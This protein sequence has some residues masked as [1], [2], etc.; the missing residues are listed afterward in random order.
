M[1]L[2]FLLL[3]QAPVV[4]PPLNADLVV[5]VQALPAIAA[6]YVATP[7]CYAVPDSPALVCQ[8]A[9]TKRDA[10]L[11]KTESAKAL[12]AMRA[13]PATQRETAAALLSRL[14]LQL[15]STAYERLS[16]Y[17]QAIRLQTGATVSP[18]PNP[19]RRLGPD[20]KPIPDDQQ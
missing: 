4:T 7:Y 17:I 2:L 13:F 14:S 12:V 11:V 6:L 1:L 18:A 9:M 15:G 8:P 16:L 20:G 3:A 10:T 5:A 19:A